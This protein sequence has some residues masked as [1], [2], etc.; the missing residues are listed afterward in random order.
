[1]IATARKYEVGTDIERKYFTSK[2]DTDYIYINRNVFYKVIRD[3]Y[4]AGYIKCIEDVNHKYME[5]LS[6]AVQKG[7]RGM[8]VNI[9]RIINRI[10]KL[11][12]KFDNTIDTKIDTLDNK[13]NSRIDK[14]ND[15]F[16]NI[17]REVGEIKNSVNTL[18]KRYSYWKSFIIAPI[19]TSVLTSIITTILIKIISKN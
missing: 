7:G 19:I 12:E 15:K 6:S 2:I 8:D 5:I 14:L 16:D 1:M 18:E 4:Y 3:V 11:D 10:D 9:D 13:L 17:N